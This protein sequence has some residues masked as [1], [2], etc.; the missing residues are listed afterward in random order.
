MLFWKW[1][2]CVVLHC[3]LLCV[4]I[5][6]WLNVCPLPSIEYIIHVHI[7]T[8]LQV[9]MFHVY[10]VSTFTYMYVLNL[11]LHILLAI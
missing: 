5:G 11:V 2:H 7:Y 1:E 6:K 10:Y 9:G 3:M 8:S 4:A